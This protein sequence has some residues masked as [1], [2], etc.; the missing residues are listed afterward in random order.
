[1]QTFVESASY[2][3]L[4]LADCCAGIGLQVLRRASALTSHG[5]PVLRRATWALLLCLA[6][7]SRRMNMRDQTT[8]FPDRPRDFSIGSGLGLSWTSG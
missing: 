6:G 4:W 7:S 3:S 2:R 8:Q 5:L 1:M